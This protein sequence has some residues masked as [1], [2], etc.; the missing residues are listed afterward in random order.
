MTPLVVSYLFKEG[1]VGLS[2]RLGDRLPN[3]A[4]R[5]RELHQAAAAWSQ[6][7]HAA[8]VPEIS[9]APLPGS[10]ATDIDQYIYADGTFNP[11]RLGRQLSM[12]LEDGQI[13]RYSIRPGAPVE[14]RDLVGRD[15]MLGRLQE[16]IAHGRSCHLR[17][18]RRY[19]KT[20]VLR[21]LQGDLRQDGRA[22]LFVDLSPGTSVAWFWVTLAQS[23]SSTESTRQAALALPELD[24]WPAI[25][26]SPLVIGQASRQLATAIGPNPWSFG[27]RLRDMQGD[28]SV[29]ILTRHHH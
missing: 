18:P 9:A 3:P 29:G 14:G 13:H 21:R 5:V 2:I 6:E 8:F 12:L 11:G 17:A 16:G 19:G 28:A 27:Q 26:A 25:S 23:A 1:K 24:G 20:S 7:K 22:C 15:E 10:I 4:D